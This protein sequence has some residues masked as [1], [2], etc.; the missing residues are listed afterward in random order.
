[1]RKIPCIKP[2]KPK[3]RPRHFFCLMIVI[4]FQLSVYAGGPK[5]TVKDSVVFNFKPGEQMWIVPEGIA[6]LH[7]EANGA[8]GGSDKGGKGGKVK[9][10]L[11]VTPGTK[12]II[13]VGSQPVSSEGGYNGGGKGCGKGY[14]GG[15]GTDIRIGGSGLEFRVLVAGGGGGAGYSGNGGSGGGLIGGEGQYPATDSNATHHIA[16]G[17]TQQAG[18]AGARAYF[19]ASGKIGLGGDGLNSH[20]NCSNDAMSGGG[21]GYFGGGGSGAGGG[22]GGSSF[23]DKNNS[24]VVHEQ[25]VVEGNGKLVIYWDKP[26][27]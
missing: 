8:Q 9:S 16:K 10:D 7:I 27:R 20:G 23:T 17:G 4:C 3:F 2:M 15:G 12:L 13:Y 25:G 22:G 11:R 14:G 26:K 1:M 5:A 24:N 18:G 19:S 21:G 6:V